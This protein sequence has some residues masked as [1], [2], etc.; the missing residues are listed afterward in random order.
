MRY[1]HEGVNAYIH[2]F[3]ILALIGG[4]IQL[5]APQFCPRKMAPVVTGFEFGW[6]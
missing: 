4:V 2:V 5:H 6:I 1:S 3:L